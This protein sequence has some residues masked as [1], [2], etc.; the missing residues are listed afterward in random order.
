MISE[1]MEQEVAHE[2]QGQTSLRLDLTAVPWAVPNWIP[3]GAV[4]VVALVLPWIT[5]QMAGGRFLTHLLITFFV[6]GIVTQCWN[7]IMGVSGI[8][9]FAQVA[10]FAV[11]GWTTAVLAKHMGIDPWISIWAAPVAATVAAIIIGLPSLRLRGVY[12]VLLTL[13]FH[14][15]LRN[16]VTTG[17]NII[18]GG[19]YGLI[20]I[21]KLHFEQLL[22]GSNA[23]IMFYYVGLLFFGVT[24]YAVW[25][26]LHSPIGMAFRTL[27]DSEHY[28]ISRGVNPFRFKLLLFAFSAFF[29][30]L[31]GGF[32]THYQGTISP[33]ILNFGVLINLLAMIVLGGW[34]TFWGP[35]AGTAFLTALSEG[36][37]AVDAYRNL[38][39]GLALALIPVLAPQGLVRMVMDP[40]R[41]TIRLFTE[42]E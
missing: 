13:A 23:I 27:R 14:E 38:A 1:E 17:P 8:F 39:L 11:G 35:I 28:A 32:M 26:I 30:G 22:G 4:V 36:L 5:T 9:S 33:S 24:T 42:T 25:R 3:V 34:G 16:Y 6:W 2:E 10:L 20:Q 21:P 19:G 41:D 40:I 37:R 29:T 12:V 15:L 31:A 18:S 7:L